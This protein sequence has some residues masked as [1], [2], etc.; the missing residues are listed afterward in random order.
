MFFEHA[1]ILTFNLFD[2]KNII[3]IY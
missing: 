1:N 3:V 2:N